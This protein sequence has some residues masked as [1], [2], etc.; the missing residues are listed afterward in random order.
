[1]RSIYLFYVILIKHLQAGLCIEVRQIRR[2]ENNHVPLVNYRDRARLLQS[3]VLYSDDTP[4][5]VVS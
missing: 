1:M 4:C 2:S 3:H 5:P